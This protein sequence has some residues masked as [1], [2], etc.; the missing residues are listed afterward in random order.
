[1]EKR[2]EILIFLSS[3]NRFFC[4]QVVVEYQ[5]HLN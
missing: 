1:M 5:I 2:A 3:Q 4:F